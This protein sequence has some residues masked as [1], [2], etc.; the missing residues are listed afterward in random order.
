VDVG[1]FAAFAKRGLEPVGAA[2]LLWGREGR[3]LLVRE[4]SSAGKEA[5]WATPGGFADAGEGPEACAVREAREEAGVDIRLTG[6]TKVIVCHVTHGARALDFTF[7][8]FEGTIA[9]GTPR[10][11]AGI[12]A[13]AWF[14]RLPDAMHFRRDYREAWMRGRPRL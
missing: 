14:D 13:I 6:L 3:I 1:E 11:G 5:A 10:P 9:R 8:Q 4:K 7:F 12:D 2:T